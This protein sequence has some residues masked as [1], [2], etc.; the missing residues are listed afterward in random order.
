MNKW[1]EN[2]T[3]IQDDYRRLTL[4]LETHT[5]SKGTDGKRY[6]MQMEMKRKQGWHI[7]IRQNTL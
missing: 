1:I 4:D 3:Y 6:S 7:Y 2:K 5:K